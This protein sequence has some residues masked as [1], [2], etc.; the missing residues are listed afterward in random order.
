MTKHKDFP[1][2]PVISEDVF[3]EIGKFCIDLT[4]PCEKKVITAFSKLLMEAP[5]EKLLNFIDN[6]CV[7]YT[8]QGNVHKSDHPSEGHGVCHIIIDGE[9]RYVSKRDN[10]RAAVASALAEFFTVESHDYHDYDGLVRQHI[11]ED[12]YYPIHKPDNSD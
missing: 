3:N 6:I 7:R 9:G 4:T 11:A 8:I 1:D 2:N 10:V 12:K 5:L